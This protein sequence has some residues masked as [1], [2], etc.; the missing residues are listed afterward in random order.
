MGRLRRVQESEGK[1]NDERSHPMK[2]AL[3]F[4]W[5]LLPVAAGAYHYG[6]GQ[7]RLRS[8]RAAEAVARAEAS[9]KPAREITA[10]SGDDAAREHWA[11]A[12]EAWSQALELL[13]PGQER[14]AR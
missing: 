7:D 8:D 11:A 1:D 12:E 9:A 14:Q 5:L 2:K 6:P 4:V 13:P 3:L 10:E